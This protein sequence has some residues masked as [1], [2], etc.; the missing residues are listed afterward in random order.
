MYYK[1]E[2]IDCEVYMQLY[3]LRTTELD[4]E[5]KNLRLVE[6]KTGLKF[7]NTFG[8]HGQLNYNRVSI[9]MGFEFEEP[10]KVDLKI[11][12]QHKEH[13][14]IFVPNNRTKLG[15]EMED[16][17]RYKLNKSNYWT[18]LKIL[19]LED[20]RKFNFPF[21][22]ILQDGIIIMYLGDAHEPKD[23]NII[24]ITKREFNSFRILE[25]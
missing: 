25:S 20:L 11:W 21:I 16:F 18:V 19:K 23:E 1:I 9:F 17:L 10:E 15:R 24:E 12:K 13:Q 14:S 5:K 7:K 22:E 3:N 2:N 4:Y 8:I 6:E